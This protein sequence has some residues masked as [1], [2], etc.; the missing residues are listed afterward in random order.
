M[1]TYANILMIASPLFFVFVFAEKLYGYF[2]FGHPFKTMDLIS[3]LSS[4]YT[5]ALKDALG[6]GVSLL[7]YKW[8][9]DNWALAHI[10]YTWLN[11]VIAFIA[12]DLAGYLGH[13]LSHA[14]NFFWNMHVIH[15]SSEEFNLAC[16]LRQSISNLVNFFTIF[17]LPAALLGVDFQIIAIVAPLHLFAQFWYHTVYIKKL[18]F[19]EKIIVTPSHH[20]V[21]HAINPIYI[22]KNH[23]QIFIIWDKL[24]G[25]FQEELDNEPPI[26]GITVP[27]QTWNPIK[28]NFQHIGLMIKDSFR[29]SSWKNVYKIWFGPTG[30]RPDDVQKKYS[31]FKIDNPQ[32]YIKYY[33]VENQLLTTWSWIQFFVCF[34]F[35]MHLFYSV[36]QVGFWPLLWYGL[37]IMASIYAYT[38]LMDGNPLSFF[39]EIIKNIFGFCVFNYSTDYFGIVLPN[40]I[41]L[42]VVIYFVI[43]TIAVFILSKNLKVNSTSLTAVPK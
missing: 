5:N 32:T 11:V 7:T 30:Y 28:I 1:E 37:F 18:G 33:P 39:M 40:S 23:S 34:G 36:G 19:L 9:V 2:K 14:S 15:H 8:M 38:E 42:L 6:L 43:S 12:I 35:L 4:G 25:T 10:P 20:R 24:F 22:D 3:S 41:N 21:H 16:A 13:R 31:I 29:T 27:A 26:Y 17:L